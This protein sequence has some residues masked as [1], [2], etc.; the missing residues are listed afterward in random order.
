[1]KFFGPSAQI[2]FYGVIAG[3]TGLHFMFS[4]ISHSPISIPISSNVRMENFRSPNTC[5]SFA[6]IKESE[7]ASEFVKGKAFFGGYDKQ[8][9]IICWLRVRLHFSSNSD[10][11]I[12][13]KMCLWFIE[14]GLQMTHPDVPFANMVFDLSGFSLSNMVRPRSVSRSKFTYQTHNSTYPHM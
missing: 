3:V 14:R 7:I 4:M 6:V 13:K 10:A 11:E 12:T 9:R 8:G 1:M 2:H 5:I